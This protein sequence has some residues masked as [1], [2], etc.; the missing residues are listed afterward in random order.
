MSIDSLYPYFK[1]D[2]LNSFVVLAIGL[3]SVLVL[4]YSF[5]FMKG[6]PQPVQ[7]YTYII[8]T[9]IASVGAVLSNNLILLL[10]FWGFLG[11]T[12]YLLINMGD[13]ASGI[14][15]KT[16]IIVG[17]SDALMLLGIGIIYHLTG[18]F[19]MDKIKISLPTTYYP[20]PT[21]AYLCIAIACFAKA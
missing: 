2:S 6:T 14:A 7:Y 12:L 10:V 13:D 18:T 5:K 4:I 19:Q 15:K 20:L 11:L 8:F 9:A 1:L 16:F 17:G 21:I 3:F